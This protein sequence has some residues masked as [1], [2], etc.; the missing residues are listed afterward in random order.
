[1]NSYQL[2]QEELNIMEAK[3]SFEIIPN[4]NEFNLDNTSSYTKLKLTPSQKMQMSALCQSMPMAVAANALSKTFTVNFPEDLPHTLM[5]LKSGGLAT[6]IVDEASGK[7]LGTASLQSAASQAMVLNAFNAMSMVT[8]Q[9]FMSQINSQLSMIS[10]K[11]DEI[12]AFLYGEKKAELISEITFVRYAFENFSSIM[13]HE[14]QRQATITN[15]QEARKIA[16]KDIEFY[17]ND[18]D[19]KS[20]YQ[21]KDYDDIKGSID[22]VQRIKNS[23]TM[24]LQL[25]VTSNVLEMQ[26]ARNYDKSYIYY[27]EK[28]TNLYVDR[29]YG[30]IL[31]SFSK[32]EGKVGDYSKTIFEKIDKQKDIDNLRKVINPLLEDENTKTKRAISQVLHAQEKCR[33]YI[34]S[35][36]GDVYIPKLA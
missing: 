15:L 22:R 29:C 32:L 24:S 23:L 6:T 14:E 21:G 31:T 12:L 11:M 3:N 17:L 18:L 34:I 16:M 8:G 35:G 19:A 13:E 2:T 28:S 7:I 4:Q 1:M 26:Y 33:Q 10:R 36:E 20:S 9:Y 27:I 30:R 5:K 25:Y